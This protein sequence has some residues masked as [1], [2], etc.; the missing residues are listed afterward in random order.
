MSITRHKTIVT[1]SQG[2]TLIEVMVSLLILAIGLLGMTAL[3]NEALKFNHAASV[4]SQAQYL[5]TDMAE[6]IRSNR[7]NNN[8]V[9]NFIEATPTPTVNCAINT[10]TSN[11]LAVWDISQWRAKIETVATMPNGESE[12]TLDIPNRTFVISIRYDWSQL[13]GVDITDGKRTVT[14]TTRI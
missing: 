1:P 13:G 5:V 6:R 11:E 2:F 9:I 4:D 8:Y 7:G 10:C 3:Q 14:V 12:I